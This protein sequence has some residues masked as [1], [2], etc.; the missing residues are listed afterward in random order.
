V[1]ASGQACSRADPSY[2][3]PAADARLIHA[4]GTR[5]EE[6]GDDV[7]RVLSLFLNFVGDEHAHRTDLL[8]ASEHASIAITIAINQMHRC[9]YQCQFGRS[10]R[11]RQR[12][13]KGTKPIAFIIRTI[14]SKRAEWRGSTCSASGDSQSGR[15]A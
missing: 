14:I 10:E 4:R 7:G 12:Q 5:I 8:R 15:I 13:A 9:Q 1:R 6:R 3:M 11:W 2:R